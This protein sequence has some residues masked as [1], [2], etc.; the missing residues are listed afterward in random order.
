MRHWI[1]AL[2]L[3][4]TICAIAAF[5]VVSA[6]SIA[7]ASLRLRLAIDGAHEGLFASSIWPCDPIQAIPC[8]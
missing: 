2:A 6:I 3:L 5:V 1:G 4:F 7:E 8:Y